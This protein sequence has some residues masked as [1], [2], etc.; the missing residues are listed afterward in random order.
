[1]DGEKETEDD[2]FSVHFIPKS[3]TQQTEFIEQFP[4]YDGR[5]TV[6][7][8]L[9]TGIDLSLPGLQKTTTGASKVIGC[10]DLTGAGDVDTSTIR[11]CPVNGILIGL[12]G[13]ELMI[14]STWENPSGEWHLGK[15]PV[16]ELYSTNVKNRI[17]NK[18]NK[19]LQKTT[20][21]LAAGLMKE[22]T[23]KLLNQKTREEINAKLQYLNESENI[24]FESPVADCIVWFD[25]NKWK[26]SIVTS[27]CDNLESAK[28]M[29]SFSEDREYGF[30][31]EECMVSYCITIHDKGNILEICVA[32]GSHGSHVAHIAAG[33]FPDN[34]EK[35]GLAP[36][37]QIISLCIGD[38][39]NRN[40][41]SQQALIRALEICCRLKVDVINFSYGATPNCVDE[42]NIAMIIK[43]IIENDRIIFVAAGGNY[44][45]GLS[46]MGFAGGKL[47]H[48]GIYVGAY[49][50][51]EMKIKV[52]GH[53]EPSNSVVFPFSSRGPCHDASW[54]VNICAPGAAFTGIP[55]SELKS[56]DLLDGTSMSCPNAAGNIACLLSAMK[57]ESIPISSFRI[58]LAIMNSA[59]MPEDV[60][61]DPYSLGSG[62]IQIL[63]AYELIKSSMSLI[64]TNITDI[65]ASVNGKR[66]IY[67]RE[68]SKINHNEEY[69]ITIETTFK[70][71]EDNDARINFECMLSLIQSKDGIK[72]NMRTPKCRL[73]S[74]RCVITIDPRNLETGAV[75]FAEIVG[76]NPLNKTL[77]PLFRIPIIV[78]VPEKVT[79]LNGFCFNK[80]LTLQPAVPQRLFLQSPIGSTYAVATIESLES[81]R[82]IKF[83]MHCVYI[84]Y[85][86]TA[87]QK[88]RVYIGPK[89]TDEFY[90]STSAEIDPVIQFSE[91]C[92]PLNPSETAIESM[93]ERD[94]IDGTPSFRL[95]LTYNF[96][97]KQY[98][99]KKGREYLWHCDPKVFCSQLFL[100]GETH[101]KQIF[102]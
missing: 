62:I 38:S 53:C 29:S 3:T 78:I 27:I 102:F 4:E 42:G 46:T 36:G 87:M 14:P 61:Q 37:A 82:D 1:M 91:F 23:N 13:R 83:D 76:I 66:G 60:K 94:I 93:K 6:I 70:N 2:G 75:H 26:A 21:L 64:P 100:K 11:N 12:T 15:K 48:S 41:L 8:I 7:A 47:H 99:Y 24:S 33:H 39:R 98:I 63:S 56:S 30:I 96:C 9:D 44:G 67:I 72:L 92:H 22:L 19:N 77:G 71:S 68:P 97:G 34:P 35:D 89:N 10:F 54:G 73:P 79:R 32:N 40:N 80:Q 57:S 43:K 16:F 51:A 86:E 65:V 90:F 95:L 49:L 18:Q 5:N 88:H 101:L 74:S 28:V 85:K 58:K 84:K 50:S 17:I 20:K 59:F 52:Y 31:S 45:P 55:K 81:D 25:G 69:Y